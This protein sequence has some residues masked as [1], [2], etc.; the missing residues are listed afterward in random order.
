MLNK[1]FGTH[2]GLIRLILSYVQVA[3]G[4]ASIT[5]F[6]PA[7]VKRL[8]F[9]CHGNICRSA[10]ADHYAQ[11]L[12]LSTASFGLST[13]SNMGAH[14]F[15]SIV[16]ETLGVSL[17]AHQTT[18]VEDFVPMA[19]DLLLAMEVRHLDKIAKIP[20]LRDYPRTL[21]GIYANPRCPHLHDPYR[22]DPRYMAVCLG[23]V[24]AAVNRLKL[25]FSGAAAAQ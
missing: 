5:R 18:A 13:T 14:A 8:V 20:A 9:V 21:L 17:S 7:H 11:Q 3:M 22:L 2:R 4:R 19:G 25:S 10:F 6:D 12:G 23:R 1:N 24:Q 15:A 16:S